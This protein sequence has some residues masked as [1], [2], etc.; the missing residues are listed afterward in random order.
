MDWWQAGSLFLSWPV[1]VKLFTMEIAV[2]IISHVIGFG[3][4]LVVS[5]VFPFIHPSTT[6]DQN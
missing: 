4:G 6:P 2:P 3:W 1:L 5:P